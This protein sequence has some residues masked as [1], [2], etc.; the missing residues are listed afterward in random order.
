MKQL[1]ILPA[2]LFNF[3]CSS[4]TFTA[5]IESLTL[6]TNS[7]YSPTTSAPFY[8]NGLRFNYTYS[9]GFWL[10]GF[11]YT[12]IKDS[13]TAGFTNLYGVK[14]LSGYNNSANFVVGQDGA[15]LTSTGTPIIFK[16][17][18]YT[19]TTFAYKS[20]K[21]GD[22]FAKKFG[23]ISGNDPDYLKLV[24]LSYSGGIK[25]DSLVLFLANYTFTNNT[26]DFI[27]NTWQFADLSSLGLSDS[28]K[29]VM[30]STD[31]S[32]GFMNTPAFFAIDNISYEK[33]TSTFIQSNNQQSVTFYPNPT[34]NSVQVSAPEEYSSYTIV[35][36]SGKLVRKGN[37]D[38]RKIEFDG[39]EPGCYF[40][41]VESFNN[42]K[43]VRIIIE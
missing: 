5:T 1:L 19:N 16:G 41:S 29:F 3:I 27:L 18:Y 33:L 42:Q 25:K 17:L 10:G 43:S 37:I 34:K 2:L 14:A 38:N 7:A 8:E 15:I 24:V 30:R 31:N 9:S 32:G 39:L 20:M 36:L 6:Q 22:S 28:L 40:L 13:S 26:Q 23:G 12:N 21:T 11:A 4:Q 35:D